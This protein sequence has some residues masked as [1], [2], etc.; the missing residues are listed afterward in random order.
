MPIMSGNSATATVNSSDTTLLNP[1]S[2]R[3]MITFAILHEQTGNAETV[4]LFISTGATSSAG[5]RIDDLTFAAKESQTPISLAGLAIPSGSF[6]IAKGGT[7]GR[8]FADLTYTQ[9]SGSS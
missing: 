2:G 8:V 4:E 1:T 7:G 6:L 9:F 3:A 5:E